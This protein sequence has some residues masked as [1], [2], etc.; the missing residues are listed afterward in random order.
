[1][2]GNYT[3]NVTGTVLSINNGGVMTSQN[4]NNGCVLNGSISTSDATH[5]I[6]EVAFTYGNC[7]GTYAVLNGVQFTGLATLEPQRLAAAAEL[8]GFRRFGDRQVRR[9]NDLQRQLDG[10][11]NLPAGALR[12]GSINPRLFA[13]GAWRERRRPT[14]IRPEVL[15]SLHGVIAAA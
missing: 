5:D 6:Y 13:H 8:G 12:V 2:S 1:M 9:D 4:A 11:C 3:D 15:G 7:T 14:A 10:C